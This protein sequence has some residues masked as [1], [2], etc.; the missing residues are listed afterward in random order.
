MNIKNVVAIF[1]AILILL[2]VIGCTQTQPQNVAAIECYGTFD[3]F[4]AFPINF[5]RADDKPLP[6]YL[7]PWQFASER[8]A[9]MHVSHMQFARHHDNREEIWFV[10]RLEGNIVIYD[11]D[12]KSWKQFSGLIE[13]TDLY[14]Y[15]L[16][17]TSN[18]T[19]WGRVHLPVNSTNTSQATVLSKLNEDNQTFEFLD[20]LASIPFVNF[21]DYVR[22]SVFLD[23][24][25]IFWIAVS[26]DALYSFDTTRNEL[27]THIQLNDVNVGSIVRA[28]DGTVYLTNRAETKLIDPDSNIPEGKVLAFQVDQ[29]QFVPVPLPHE[30]WIRRFSRLAI[31]END[32]L[33]LDTL[34]YIEQDESWHNVHP[35]PDDL[36]FHES[37][38]HWATPYIVLESSNNLL[39]LNKYPDAGTAWYD[40]DSSIGCVISEESSDVVEDSQGNVWMLV[41]RSLY[42]LD[43]S[44]LDQSLTEIKALIDFKIERP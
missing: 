41:G 33:W 9:E 39:W 25:G 1:I 3:E 8:P 13:E 21:D 7:S 19:V 34:G 17:V 27:T 11:I 40:R 29:N 10:D 36:N 5:K 2:I 15:D 30:R 6:N 43:L 31:T 4:V 22:T 28:I 24:E 44:V 26:D 38:L 18:Q 20:E 14:V 12:K 32:Q 35:F 37:D 42:S 16:F 23:H